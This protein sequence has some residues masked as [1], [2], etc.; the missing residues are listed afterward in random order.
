MGLTRWRRIL[1]DLDE[2]L[3]SVNPNLGKKK[4]PGVKE[5]WKSGHLREKLT[6]SNAKISSVRARWQVLGRS[7]FGGGLY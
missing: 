1:R 7:D 2:W 6:A 4:R 3:N 5:V